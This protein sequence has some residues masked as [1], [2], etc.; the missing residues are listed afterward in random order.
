MTRS[1]DGVPSGRRITVTRMVEEDDVVV[2]EG[3]V[4]NTLEDGSVLS[5][6]YCHVFLMR[7]GRIRHLTS[8]L[9]PVPLEG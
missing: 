8:Y 3:T 6:L 4:R 5:L 7:E 1:R 9:M 2:A